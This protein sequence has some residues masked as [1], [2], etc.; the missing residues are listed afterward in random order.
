[1]LL[2]TSSA[3]LDSDSHLANAIRAHGRVVLPVEVRLTRGEPA[4]R[5]GLPA[6]M[7]IGANVGTGLPGAVQLRRPNERFLHAASAFGHLGFEADPDGVVRTD[8][9]AV[10]TGEGSLPSL[11]TA[12]VG[13]A[14][15]VAPND[16]VITPASLR[17]GDR[18][19]A[20]DARQRLLPQFASRGAFK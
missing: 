11:A 18:A 6:S 3:R 15:N 7:L 14:L 20:L 2:R 17:L 13:A 4:S 16:M 19:L 8:A 9:V 12:I 5:S 1:R 10:R